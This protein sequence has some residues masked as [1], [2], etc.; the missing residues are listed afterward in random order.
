[1]DQNTPF[2]VGLTADF[3]T[4]GRGLLDD[5]LAAV[6]E[7]APGVEYELMP[8]TGGIATAEVLDRY[9]AVIALDYAFPAACFLGLERLA[10]IARWG[11]G[12]DRIDIKACTEAG[13]LVALTRDSVRRPVAEGNFALM[14]AL[15]KNLPALD[16]NCRSGRWWQ[17][18][19]RLINLEGRALGSVGMGNI[20]GEMFR[21]ARALRMGRL[22]AYAPFNSPVEAAEL[23]VELADLDTVF[24]E[25]DFVTINCPLTEQTR[26]MIGPR[27]LNAMKPTA[28][29]I[30]AARGPI[31]QEK[32]LIEALR[33]RR[34]AGAG[35]DVYEDEPM[36][37]GH[38]LAAL[39]NVILTA[40][41]IAKTEEC[42]R[43]T[44]LS[45]CRSVL[46]VSQ[47]N[48]PLFLANPEALQ[49]PRVRARLSAGA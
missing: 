25:S 19:P 43:D 45:V 6:L 46:A 12:F 4:E 47:G 5:A 38:P 33:V 31:V 30:N 32:A 42:T 36:P 23:G 39:D 1:M 14:F 37:A 40:H 2:R 8:D 24:R 44:S 15:A 35:L 48:P 49:R 18:P 34:I 26:G 21:M 28:Y 16:R 11:V 29:F 13:V 27:Q 9:D 10:V 20:A 7:P 22:L 3:A 41:R 17:D